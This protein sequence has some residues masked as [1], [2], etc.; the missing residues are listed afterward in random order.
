MILNSNS[1][2]PI[3]VQ[4]AEYLEGEILRDSIRPDEKIYSQYQLAEMFNINPATAAKG[5]NLLADEDILYKRRG[6]GM[7]VAADAK[8]IILTKRTNTKL[9]ELIEE[10]VREAR[11]LGVS[12]EELME[13]IQ[14]EGEE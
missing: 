1:M 3:Y 7:F 11:Q 12:K 6:L 14:K 4:I 5:L 2:K 8:K 9:K 13:M 10:T